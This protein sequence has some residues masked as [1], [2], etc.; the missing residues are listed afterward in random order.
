MISPGQ[1]GDS[2]RPSASRRY[3][4][5]DGRACLAAATVTATLLG[6][7]YLAL[8]LAGLPQRSLLISIPAVSGVWVA[9]ACGAMACG[10]RDGIGAL[11]RGGTVID[12]AG[13]ILIVLCL[14]TPL[15]LLSGVQ[16]YLILAAMGV[17]AVAMARLARGRG[18]R[19]A[20]A[21]LSG[22]ILIAAMASPLWA[23]SLLQTP[24]VR[25][26]ALAAAIYPNSLYSI[27]SVEGLRYVWHES[28]LMYDISGIRDY[29]PPRPQWWAPVAIYALAAAVIAVTKLLRKKPIVTG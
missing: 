16:I 23:P 2:P 24:A 25:Q 20:L 28:G 8:H 15:P 12:T 1:T 7:L 26:A 17:F 18:A 27:W 14:S 13:G 4:D 21:A 11:L 29:A 5:S 19:L 22:A 3:W 6:G 9:L 10:A